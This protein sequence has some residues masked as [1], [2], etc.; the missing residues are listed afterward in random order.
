MKRLHVLPAAAVHLFTGLGAICA[1]LALS[2]AS[3]GAFEQ[4][5]AWLGAALIIDGL[6]GPVA[7]R[8]SIDGR[9]PHI[10]GERL[11]LI[12]DY[13][14]YVA[15]PAFILVQAKLVPGGYA[16]LAGSVILLSS[17]YHFA[18]QGSKTHDCFFVGFPC[19]WNVIV[20]YFF[21]LSVP[22]LTAFI[23]V[24]VFAVMTFIPLKWSHPLRVAL[25]RPVTILI[26]LVWAAASVWIVQHGFPGAPQAQIILLLGG[27]YFLALG[28]F[29]SFLWAR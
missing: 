2:A 10:S 14:N 26:T 1:L 17:L 16:I 23:A 20:F 22:P 12:I 28:A 21:A 3:K 13:L 15:V 25:L 7:R 9:M 5:F 19:V 11:D 18:H 4:A 6:D 29:R 24:M 8:L 27:L